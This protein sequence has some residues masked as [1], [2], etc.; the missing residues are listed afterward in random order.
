MS[1][2]NLRTSNTNSLKI[3]AQLAAVADLLHEWGSPDDL[4][5]EAKVRA[6][7]NEIERLLG[8]LRQRSEQVSRLQ[9][10]IQEMQ[11][12]TTEQERSDPDDH[13]PQDRRP[14]CADCCDGDV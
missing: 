3:M 10:G 5:A 7:V 6:G 9:N 12:G 11:A 8:T 1:E 4:T 13:D 2:A 14:L